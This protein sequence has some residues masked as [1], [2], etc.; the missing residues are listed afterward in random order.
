MSKKKKK[1]KKKV[2]VRYAGILKLFMWARV[3]A[4]GSVLMGFPWDTEE[5][6][7]EVTDIGR[8]KINK[9]EFITK[10]CAERSKIS[11]HP[12]GHI[13]VNARMGSSA[14]AIDRATVVGTKFEKIVELQ[15]LAEILLPKDLPDSP[16]KCAL[17][18]NDILIDIPVAVDD[19]P[20][21]CTISCV[22]N[23]EYRKIDTTEMLLEDSEWESVQEFKVDTLV[24]LWIVRKS[25]NDK[26]NTDILTVHLLGKPKWGRG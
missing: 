3:T 15:H 26:V 5:S 7:E 12:S 25:K 14:D 22:S 16:S 1:K 11:F 8:R 18:D 6:V 9:V 4:D 24:W 2:L 13:K 21:R 10:T 20:T 19:K 17:T 23:E